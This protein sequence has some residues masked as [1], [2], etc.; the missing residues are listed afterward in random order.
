ME[1]QLPGFHHFCPT[2]TQLIYHRRKHPVPQMPPTRSR[3]AGNV[4]LPS[5]PTCQA[6]ANGDA[7]MENADTVLAG[8]EEPD[9]NDIVLIYTGRHMWSSIRPSEPGPFSINREEDIARGSFRLQV[10]RFLVAQ[11]VAKT[12]SSVNFRVGL[13]EVVSWKSPLTLV[14]PPPLLKSIWFSVAP[15][16]RLFVGPAL[17]KAAMVVEVLGVPASNAKN[18]TARYISLRLQPFVNVHDVWVAQIPCAN[19]PTP[20]ESTNRMAVLAS[21]T[22]G[23]DGGVDPNSVHAIPGYI[24]VGGAECELSYIGRLPWCT[25]CRSAARQ[26]HTFDNCPRRLCFN[27]RES[28][29]SRVNAPLK[30]SLTPCQRSK[31]KERV[32]VPTIS[33]MGRSNCIQLICD[34][35]RLTPFHNATPSLPFTIPSDQ[36][37]T[38]LCLAKTPAFSFA[39]QPGKLKTPTFMTILPRVR[40]PDGAPALSDSIHMLHIW[41]IHVPLQHDAHQRFGSEDLPQLSRLDASSLDSRTAAI[42]GADWN[43]VDSRVL[44]VF[45][46]TSSAKQMPYGLLHQAGLVDAFRTLH[47]TA[48]G[49]TRDTKILNRIVSAGR[50]DGISITSN[51]VPHLKSVTT[52]PSLSGHSIV[53]IRLGTSGSRIE[54]GPRTWRLHGDAHLQ[55]RF[56]LRIQQFA[57]QLP[58]NINHAPVPSF[59]AFIE[60][61]RTTTAAISTSLSQARQRSDAQRH[62][63]FQQLTSLDIRRGDDTRALFLHLLAHLRQLDTVHVQKS[64]SDCNRLHEINMFRPTAW[65]IPRLESRSFTAT[66]EFVDNQDAHSTPA[67]KLLAICRFYTTL[68]T[69]KPRS[70]ITEEAASILLGSVQRRIKSTTRHTIEA[71]FTVEELK[72]VLARSPESSAPGLDGLTYPLLQATS[73]IFLQR[74]CALGN[75]LLRGH[76]LSEGEPMLRGVLLPKKG[77]LSQLANYRPLSIAAAAFRILGGAVSNRLQPA[78]AKVVHTA[79]TGFIPTALVLAF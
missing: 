79:Q 63:L 28:G 10:R 62:Q 16:Q 67:A 33:T 50:I 25:T 60:R 57:N 11:N 12:D 15:L 61:L 17:P 52:R 58:P 19:N 48:S 47:P 40:I 44:D 26:Y 74:L 30:R 31:P 65:V 1:L 4:N 20:L 76:H 6:P 78:A 46:S 36:L 70:T 73:D 27:C 68:F 56:S 13:A 39:I 41:S 29:H 45:P 77:D 66:P 71:A 51:L 35:P 9:Q 37:R 18:E 69:P 5:D 75:A 59:F 8:L 54:L 7:N 23:K 2:Q 64:V 72:A 43:A 42:V 32:V 22:A 38:K 24:K 34:F 53:S 14:L 21:S 49:F 55:H 3:P